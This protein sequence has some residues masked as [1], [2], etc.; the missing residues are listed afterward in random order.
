M[1]APAWRRRLRA[2][3]YEMLGDMRNQDPR[4]KRYPPAN[5]LYGRKPR[6]S[7]TITATGAGHDTMV[8]T[9]PPSEL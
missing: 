7:S 4:G 1:F 9:T 8:S 6:H 3:G 5:R 2:Q